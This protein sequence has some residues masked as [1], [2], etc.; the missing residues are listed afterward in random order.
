MAYL[1]LL[2]IYD[3]TKS[4]HMQIVLRITFPTVPLMHMRGLIKK[5]SFTFMAIIM[6]V[7]SLVVIFTLLSLNKRAFFCFVVVGIIFTLLC[8]R[9]ICFGKIMYNSRQCACVLIHYLSIKWIPSFRHMC[10]CIA[11]AVGFRWICGKRLSTILPNTD[12]G[13]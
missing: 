1:Y 11:K 3:Q 7:Q 6:V 2:K 13:W 8:A 10:V 9:W 5:F 12:N 4:I